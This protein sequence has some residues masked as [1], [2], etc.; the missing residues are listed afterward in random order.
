MN[1][2]RFFETYGGGICAGSFFLL[3][4]YI[5]YWIVVIV[6]RR[7]K[8]IYARL[9]ARGYFPQRADDGSV[10]QLLSQYASIYP[11]DPLIDAD[12]PAWK[13]RRA[14]LQDQSGQKRLVVN[15]GRSQ[16]DHAGVKNNHTSCTATV[17]VETRVL[18][19]RHDVHLVPVKNN[20]S[21]RW[22]ERY[23]L[24]RVSSGLDAALLTHYEVYATPDADVA[25]PPELTQVLIEVCPLLVEQSRFCF[26][27]GVS[28]RFQ[29]DAWS[30]TTSNEVYKQENMDLLLDA[31][32][33][34]SE[35][36][37]SRQ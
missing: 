16:R 32:D 8:E 33:R 14:A 24:A 20:G 34:I 15:A 5:F 25:L 2:V 22:K 35:A 29:P 18:S 30:I 1:V 36:L 10:A 12:V 19:L 6:P 28:L 26:Q 31:A 9:E 21:I 3:M 7:T 17:V 11:K 27:H 23:G 13:V 37:G 4:V